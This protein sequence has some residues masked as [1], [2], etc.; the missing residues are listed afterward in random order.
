MRQSHV[1]SC[2]I[3]NI[4]A[5]MLVKLKEIRK[6]QTIKNTNHTDYY[7]LLISLD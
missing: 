4:F 5:D 1:S 2:Q 6:Y 3:R 7:N